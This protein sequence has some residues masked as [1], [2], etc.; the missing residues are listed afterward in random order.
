MVSGS[1]FFSL[2]VGSGTQSVSAFSYMQDVDYDA[3]QDKRLCAEHRAVYRKEKQRLS[4]SCDDVVRSLSNHY[5]DL[6][7]HSHGKEGYWGKTIAETFP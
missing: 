4:K 3:A 2:L 5:S 1:R 6:I 7:L